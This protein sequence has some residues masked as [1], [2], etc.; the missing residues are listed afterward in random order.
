MADAGPT[1]GLSESLLIGLHVGLGLFQYV[2]HP[3]ALNVIALTDFLLRE[4][5]LRRLPQYIIF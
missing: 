5:I 3:A 4:S 2:L 1:L